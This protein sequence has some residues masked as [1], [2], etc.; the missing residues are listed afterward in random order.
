MN[1]ILFLKFIIYKRANN[2]IAL[3]SFI[4]YFKKMFKC[5]D[6]N[7]VKTSKNSNH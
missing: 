4:V 5:C 7:K 3:K 1:L 2:F 6:I